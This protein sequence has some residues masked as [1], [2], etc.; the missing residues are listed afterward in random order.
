MR[1]GKETWRNCNTMATYGDNGKLSPSI[2]TLMTFVFLRLLRWVECSNFHESKDGSCACF[3]THAPQWGLPSLWTNLNH[4]DCLSCWNWAYERR[5]EGS[6]YPVMIF[7]AAFDEGLGMF[8]SSFSKKMALKWSEMGENSISRM[9][10]LN[11]MFFRGIQLFVVGLQF[12]HTLY[13]SSKSAISSCLV[14]NAFNAVRCRW[15]SQRNPSFNPDVSGRV[16]S[17]SAQVTQKRLL[18][19]QRSVL[20]PRLSASFATWV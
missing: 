2:A 4:F 17:L 1:G 15:E 13:L 11:L 9:S 10:Q 3:E 12:Q 18:L 7:D 20:S 6:D 5:H 14:F 19:W 16:L 8:R